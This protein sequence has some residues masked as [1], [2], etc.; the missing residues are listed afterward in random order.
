MNPTEK[1]YF[2]YISKQ[3]N[4]RYSTK[5]IQEGKVTGVRG[6]VIYVLRKF[7]VLYHA[8]LDEVRQALG[9]KNL[10]AVINRLAPAQE[11]RGE[12]TEVSAMMQQPDGRFALE[13][14]KALGLG[15]EVATLPAFG[16]V[17]LELAALS[18]LVTDQNVPL[19]RPKD[20]DGEKPFEIQ[21]VK[22]DFDL[23]FF[24]QM[25][26]EMNL[27]SAM[28]LVA[29]HFW[30][31]FD[32][33]FEAVKRSPEGAAYL[34]QMIEVMDDAPLPAGDLI[35]VAL[36]H[37]LSVETVMVG[38]PERRRAWAELVAWCEAL[39]T[40]RR[41]VLEMH[42]CKVVPVKKLKRVSA[43]LLPSTER[44]YAEHFGSI[45]AGVAFACETLRMLYEGELTKNFIARTFTQDELDLLRELV[46]VAGLPKG[47][48]IGLHLLH[49]LDR[50]IRLRRTGQDATVALAA[51]VDQFETLIVK[52][53]P[54]SVLQRIALFV[55][56]PVG[57]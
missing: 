12:S 34:P 13:A 28:S 46:S 8:T 19:I 45:T 1:R 48:D 27:V 2:I 5:F 29:E 7:P 15:A 52:I 37:R 11:R 9:V 57:H 21:C 26:G 36:A 35:G 40:F 31:W 23:P 56:L 47:E 14:G 43:L 18:L 10:L 51:T 25:F 55:F 39:P 24:V 50:E 53:Q 3:A 49:L 38:D 54:L 16:R 44:F 22:K 6:G 20:F 33:E 4:A 42:L 30:T 32:Q 17:C 41:A